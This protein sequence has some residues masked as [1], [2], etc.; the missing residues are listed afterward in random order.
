[1]VRRFICILVF[2]AEVSYGAQGS[3]IYFD[4]H[5]SRGAMIG[6]KLYHFD[7]TRIGIIDGDSI[8]YIEN[9]KQAAQKNIAMAHDPV[10]FQYVVQYSFLAG[11]EKSFSK[12]L[13][14]RGAI[15]YQK[16]L[17][18][19]HAATIPGFEKGDMTEAPFVSAEIVRHWISIPVDFKVT[20]PMGRSGLYLAVGP[21]ASIL[22]SSKYSDSLANTT[23]D[24][25]D[26]TPGFNMGIGFRLGAEFPI[27]KAGFLFVESGYHYGLLNISLVPSST[28][29]EGEITLLAMGFRMNIP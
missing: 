4:A 5:V 16:A 17:L 14:V 3:G 8:R 21:K 12:A 25:S 6:D 11:Y 13:S 29:K 9:R 10:E 1:M 7:G 20:L 18:D 26:L 19:A 24:L 2:I 27:S 15:G 22:L 28:T 23:E